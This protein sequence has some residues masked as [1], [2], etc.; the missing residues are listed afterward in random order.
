MDNKVYKFDYKDTDKKIEIE[1]YGLVF[2]I[3][4]LNSE[5][6]EELQG[7]NRNDN[8]ILERQIESILGEGCIEKINNKREKD[9]YKK[10]TVDIELNILGCILNAYANATVDNL[11]NG[12]NNTLEN[13]N[14]KVNDMINMGN[15]EQRRNYN[16]NYKNNN[17][18]R[19]RRRY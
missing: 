19:N 4:N 1:L 12:I 13:V 15:R 2:E 9:G 5:K 14:N 3:K 7:I 10:L 16:R 8:S 6:V 11:S 18:R 17:Y